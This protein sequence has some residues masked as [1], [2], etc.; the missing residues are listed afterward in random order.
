MIELE[1][2]YKIWVEMWLGGMAGGAFFSA[3]LFERFTG[4]TNKRLL[5]LATF[6]A[7]PLVATALLLALLDLGKP[8]WFWHLLVSFRPLSALWVGAWLLQS[9]VG[10]NMLMALMYLAE[11]RRPERA[12][13]MRRMINVLSWVNFVIAGALMAYSGTLIA[14]T[15]NPLWT[16]APLLPPMFVVTGIVSGLAL[17]VVVG[18]AYQGAWKVPGQMV[19]RLA[20]T[21]PIVI[22]LQLALI[23]GHFFLLTTS[24]MEG[25]TLSMKVI[26]SE[27]L[28]IP[29]WLMSAA[30]L[31]SLGSIVV[32][33]RKK[34][35]EKAVRGSLLFAS[36]CL[37][38]AS[39]LLRAIM[40]V[41]GQL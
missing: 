5:R 24:T 2:G 23:G 30:F 40:I 19:Q 29:F 15:N 14:S 39:L 32:A 28:A 8:L 9:F 37:L 16:A 33:M 36:V 4:E 31:V 22:I 21:I 6:L 10:I 34:I 11:N 41:G 18:L 27:S 20:G 35:E 38:S 3:F 12:A 13:S 7:I 26:V 1:W 25:A 17:L